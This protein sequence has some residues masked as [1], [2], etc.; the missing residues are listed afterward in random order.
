MKPHSAPITNGILHNGE[1]AKSKRRSRNGN[2]RHVTFVLPHIRPESNETSSQISLESND[3]VDTAESSD[4]S[5][6][7]LGAFLTYCQH[8]T[9]EP[10]RPRRRRSLLID[11]K[12]QTNTRACRFEKQESNSSIGSLDM[13]DVSEDLPLPGTKFD[14]KIADKTRNGMQDERLDSGHL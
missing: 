8:F 3:T 1:G 13:S 4:F 14:V 9:E 12:G 11:E 10:P 2:D 7:E 6:K 5:S